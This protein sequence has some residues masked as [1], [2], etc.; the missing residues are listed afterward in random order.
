V[1]NSQKFIFDEK[2]KKETQIYERLQQ[3]EDILKK[4]QLLA[5]MDDAV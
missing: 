3:E 5:T 1:E 4:A 2:T